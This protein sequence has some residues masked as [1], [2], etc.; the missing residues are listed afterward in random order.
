MKSFHQ[1]T[2][3]RDEYYRDNKFAVDLIEL[4]LKSSSG[5]NTP[6]YLAT[7]MINIEFESPSAPTAGVNTYSAQGEFMS[8]SS[9]TEQFDVVLGKVNLN[10]SGL[11]TGYI[12]KFVNTEPEGKPVHIYKCFL[13]LNTLETVSEPINMFAGEIYNVAISEGRSSCQISLQVSSKFA[14]FE[15]RA[16][17]MTNDW[18]NWNFQGS[19]YDRA[20][21]QTGYIGNTEFLWGRS[22]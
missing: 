8:M 21:A 11:P 4:H 5:R 19:T 3:L 16:G 12:D 13:D 22:S 17:R 1:D 15:R 14:D 7:G 6:L 10:L 20:M 2:A 18:S 9:I